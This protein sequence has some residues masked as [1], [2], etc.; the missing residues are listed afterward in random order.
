MANHTEYEA[1][2]SVGFTDAVDTRSNR[3]GLE[4]NGRGFNEIQGD[5]MS[6]R[7]AQMSDAANESLLRGQDAQAQALTNLLSRP[8][9]THY[10]D[11]WDL[12]C[13]L[14]HSSQESF[15]ASVAAYLSRSRGAVEMSRAMSLLRHIPIGA[16]DDALQD[17]GIFLYMTAGNYAAAMDCFSNGLASR[18]SGAGAGHLLGD[19]LIKE[20]WPTLL[21]VWLAFYRNLT[22]REKSLAQQTAHLATVR[23]P[24]D[25]LGAHDTSAKQ[26]NVPN[27]A[28]KFEAF[29]QYLAAEGAGPVQAM[30]LY[31]DTRDGFQSLRRWIAEQA[32]QQPCSPKQAMALLEVWGD[33]KM[34]QRYLH[35]M[36]NRAS[37]GSETRTSLASLSDVYLRYRKLKGVR[38]SIPL[39]RKMFNF[40]YPLD[41]AGL[42]EVFRD[43]HESWG[44]LDRWGYEKF[45]KY[46]AS[47]GDVQA[48]RDLWARFTKSFPD[49][50]KSPEGFRS[51][52]NVYAEIGDVSGAEQEMRTME[53]K[54]GIQPDLG[55][56]NLL[57]KC[58]TKTNDQARA[59]KCF[60]SIE[61]VLE[62]DSMSYASIMAMAAN[63]GDLNTVLH[64]FNRSQ[65][66]NIAASWEMALSL[67]KVYCHN[68]RL[69]DAEKICVELA[70]RKTT[71]AA[72]WNQLIYHYGVRGR[73]GK[74]Y[75][76]LH[77]M[78]SYGL[79]WSHQTHEHLLQA[80]T[81]THQ[82]Q[83]AYQ[84]LQTACQN[85]LFPVK[86][87]HYAIVMQGAVR[88]RQL[89]L[90][91]TIMSEMMSAGLTV[92]FKA[93]VAIVEASMRR[94]LSATRT[95]VMAQNLVEHVRAMLPSAELATSVPSTRSPPTWT[96]PHGLAVIKKQTPYIGRAI[97]LL[98]RL[99]DFASVAE[100]VDAYTSVFSE[101]KENGHLPPDIAAA[102]MQGHLQ[103]GQLNEVHELWRKTFLGVVARA[104]DSAGKAYPARQ[105]ELARPL[106]VMVQ[107]LGQAKDG[108]G[109]LRTTEQ[110]TSSGFRLTRRNWNLIIRSLAD[111]G[112]WERAMAW[113]EQMLMPRWHGW[114]P[115]RRSARDRH[116][117]QNQRVLAAS[118]STVFSLQREWLKLRKLAA[119]SGEI[120]SKLR[121]IERQYPMLHHA[122]ITMDYEHVPATWVI[123]G[124]GSM[125]RAI[126]NML[127]P[128]SYD[129][130]RAMKCALQRQ[131]RR[132]KQRQWSRRVARSSF[133]VVVRRGQNQRLVTRPVREGDLRNLGAMLRKELAA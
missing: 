44:D 81:R 55:S 100:L 66:L 103:D 25:L 125:N 131:L 105:Y 43:W 5:S 40:C 99:R 58:Y 79:E 57:L 3:T 53:Q 115:P 2:L 119:W 77:T 71:S 47:S 118:R 23:I 14:D 9:K 90:A 130:L 38:T 62:P 18:G 120:S 33:P 48:A 129:E 56:W 12:Y 116:E 60:Q 67:V 35:R 39:L 89:D 34:Y 96:S 113:C 17:A 86:A 50:L 93:H 128:L 26:P 75:S 117:M 68:G 74:C 24:P 124:K 87:E 22:T 83:S 4:A 41:T 123:P 42:A 64:Y 97:M 7:N 27:L 88:T 76:L 121:N 1:S 122:F 106:S 32:L 84:L 28:E 29:E 8:N 85:G 15:R 101:Y 112:H 49:A 110:L 65:K 132:E 59:I 46:Y 11:A 69:M 92:P 13:R 16:W 51:I 52:L 95:R 91:E 54:Y 61:K 30:T 19:A 70:E 78:K 10:D 36:L 133:H 21:K 98:V 104:M 114:K 82:V 80:M 72:V 20:Q 126:K 63:Q 109:L 37:K 73:L 108:W 127:K 31:D 107:A 6:R 102:L 45:L 94:S 111:T